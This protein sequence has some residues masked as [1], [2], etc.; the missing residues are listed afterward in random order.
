F[1]QAEDGIRGWSVTGVQ[2]CALPILSATVASISIVEVGTGTGSLTRLLAERAARVETFEIDATV[3]D[4]AT[5]ELAGLGNVTLHRTD[6]IGRAS[7][8]GRSG[9]WGVAAELKREA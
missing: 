6:E 5:Q 8:R 9:R 1:F 3:A 4:I 2:T 7:G